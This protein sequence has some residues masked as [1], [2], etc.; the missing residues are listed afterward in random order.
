MQGERCGQSLALGAARIV[1]Q[2]VNAARV[3]RGTPISNRCLHESLCLRRLHA[4]LGAH[5]VEGGGD[6]LVHVV[7]LVA[8]QAAGEDDVALLRRELLVLLVQGL[9]PGVVDRVVRLVARLPVRGVLAVLGWSP[10][11]KC[12]CS[13][14]RV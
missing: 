10:N 4:E 7:V 1:L 3:S 6:G 12:L 14:T 11:S 5:E 8:T 2:M 13:M 9:V